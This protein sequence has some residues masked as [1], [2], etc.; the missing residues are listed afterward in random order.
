MTA[1]IGLI[2]LV[3][4]LVGGGMFL[5]RRSRLRRLGRWRII[6][7]S[8]LIGVG[9]VFLVWLAIMV[10]VVGPSMRAI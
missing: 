8:A 7:S 4:L 10:F 5:L 6:I 2:L 3:A 9:I 1:I